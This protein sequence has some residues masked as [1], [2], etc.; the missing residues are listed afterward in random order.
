[1]KAGSIV[2]SYG[3]KF[4]KIVRVS[5]DGGMF[6]LSAWVMS[7]DAAAVETVGVL[8]LND[9][10]MSQVMNGEA[11]SAEAPKPS[12]GRKPKAEEEAE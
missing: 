9:F 2:E 10:G 7:K 3:G 12:R 1:M 5:E 4:A 11:D 6:T 8:T